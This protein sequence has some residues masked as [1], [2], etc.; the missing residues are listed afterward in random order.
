MN[1]T[2]EQLKAKM[3][4]AKSQ[5]SGWLSSKDGSYEMALEDAGYYAAMKALRELMTQEEFNDL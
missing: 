4:K 1:T 5:C 2:I 3:V